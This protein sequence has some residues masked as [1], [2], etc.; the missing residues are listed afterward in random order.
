MLSSTLAMMDSY[1]EDLLT[2]TGEFTLYQNIIFYNFYFLSFWC[3][4]PQRQCGAFLFFG[5]GMGD[6]LAGMQLT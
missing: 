2:T 4:K 1:D 6:V 3:P 5:F